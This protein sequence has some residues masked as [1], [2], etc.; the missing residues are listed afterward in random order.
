[1]AAALYDPAAA[2][3]GEGRFVAYLRAI[4]ALI[5]PG[6]DKRL[7]F[8]LWRAPRQTKLAGMASDVCDRYC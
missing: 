4:R 3:R 2:Y 7:V 5:A 1:M 6:G 8:W